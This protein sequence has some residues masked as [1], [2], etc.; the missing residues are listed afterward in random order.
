MGAVAVVSSFKYNTRISKIKVARRAYSELEITFLYGHSR[1]NVS[2]VQRNTLSGEN[3]CLPVEVCQS[4]DRERPRG[5]C[6]V[7]ERVELLLERQFLT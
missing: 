7:E 2:Q 6:A 3:V 5:A 1:R 4:R